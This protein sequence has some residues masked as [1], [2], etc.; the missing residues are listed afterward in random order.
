[1]TIRERELQALQQ[2]IRETEERL[3]EQE[4]RL[5]KRR[6]QAV[7]Q[8]PAANQD[9]P[10]ENDKAPAQSPS[11]APSDGHPSDEGFTDSSAATSNGFDHEGD[12]DKGKAATAT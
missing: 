4:E 10:G 1:M 5:N 8:P 9:T 3:K 11:S 12:D 7:G 6:S 2:K